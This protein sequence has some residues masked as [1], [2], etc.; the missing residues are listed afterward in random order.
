MRIVMLIVTLFIY[1]YEGIIA[2]HI[3]HALINA[4]IH[5]TY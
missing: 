4:L 5:D 1:T 2:M 3:Y